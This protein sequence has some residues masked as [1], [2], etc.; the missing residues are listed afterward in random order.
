MSVATLARQQSSS[1]IDQ[2]YQ[3]AHMTQGPRHASKPSASLIASDVKHGD[4][5]DDL[6]R[7]GAS[8]PCQVDRVKQAP[9]LCPRSGRAAAHL[10]RAATPLCL[11][12]D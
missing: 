5:R 12:Y 10:L 11:N 2:P 7:D 4:F 9:S 1:A 6:F 8:I 3:A